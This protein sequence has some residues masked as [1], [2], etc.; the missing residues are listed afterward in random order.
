MRG[1]L[2]TRER[3]D[4]VDGRTPSERAEADLRHV[5]RRVRSGPG[6]TV[7]A[8]GDGLR[9]HPRKARRPL[10]EYAT[11]ATPAN[12]TAL[13]QTDPLPRAAGCRSP[14]GGQWKAS[15]GGYGR[16][17]SD[18]LQRLALAQ[19]T[20]CLRHCQVRSRGIPASSSLPA[21]PLVVEESNPPCAAWPRRPSPP[22]PRASLN[23][24]LAPPST[25][26]LAASEALRSDKLGAAT[27]TLMQG[28]SALRAPPRPRATKI[29]FACNSR[30]YTNAVSVTF[31][32]FCNSWSY[33]HGGNSAQCNSRSYTSNKNWVR[34]LTTSTVRCTHV[35]RTLSRRLPAATRTDRPGKSGDRAGPLSSWGSRS[36]ATTP[37][38]WSLPGTAWTKTTGGNRSDD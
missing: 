33:S 5:P 3:P 8:R 18:P 25:A 7:S 38:W 2:R 12:F 15:G 22:I 13:D 26:L 31:R 27:T 19:L 29:S 4:R 35:Q 14:E 9:C 24:C 34:Q 16:R 11:V 17:R 21:R 1:R 32:P 28:R 36:N 23:R 10:V 20:L 6:R 37:T 30:S